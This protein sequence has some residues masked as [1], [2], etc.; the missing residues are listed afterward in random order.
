MTKSAERPP[1]YLLVVA[2][3]LLVWRAWWLAVSVGGGPLLLSSAYVRFVVIN[4]VG[5]IGAIALIRGRR[6]GY[7]L[8]ALTT[9]HNLYMGGHLVATYLSTPRED[10]TFLLGGLFIL[11]LGVALP[12]ILLFWPSSWRWF[13]AQPSPLASPVAQ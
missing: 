3:Y 4:A 11:A 7:V 8:C 2:W 5:L 1:R 9:L 13:R 12:W 6:W 10:V